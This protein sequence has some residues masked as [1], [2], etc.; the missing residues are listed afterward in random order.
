MTHRV[1]TVATGSDHAGFEYKR[2][3]VDLLKSK[4]IE[5][6]DFGTSSAESTDYPDY[7]H[8]VARSVAAGKA[9]VGI[10]VCGT[11]I[12]MSITAN[13]HRGIRAANVESKMA[14]RMAREHNNANVLAIG[15]RLLSWEQAVDI[16]EEFLSAEFQGGRHQRRVDKIEDAK[17]P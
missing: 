7:A 1:H 14:A 11:G 6:I 10:L 12:G 16:I 15:S 4:G 17:K 9:E 2:Q 3:I 8:E 13:K 5:V